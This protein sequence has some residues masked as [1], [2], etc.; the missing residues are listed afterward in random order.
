MAESVDKERLHDPLEVVEAKVVHG[1]GLD[2]MNDPLSLISKVF[3][4][5]QIIEYGV[6]DKRTHVFPEEQCA[7]I[8]LWA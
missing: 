7:V 4:N 1:V 3:I 2:R 6:D 5:G 8:D